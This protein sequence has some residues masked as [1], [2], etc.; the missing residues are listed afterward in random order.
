MKQILLVVTL[1]ALCMTNDGLTQEN[2][3][4]SGDASTPTEQSSED[5]S[6]GKKFEKRVRVTQ[7]YNAKGCEAD[8]RIEYFQKGSDAHVETMLVNEACGASSGDYTVRIRYKDAQ[9]EI[10]RLEFEETWDRDDDADVTSEKDYFVG[11][12]IDIVR[13]NTRGL[14]CNCK[15]LETEKAPD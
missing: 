3:A 12:D 15:E 7:G 5:K 2:P 9:G 11:D 10:N 4:A 6:E 13:V 14:S 8:L 1:L